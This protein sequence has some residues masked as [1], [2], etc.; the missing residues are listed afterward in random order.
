MSIS[1]EFL[2]ILVCPVDKGEL[3]EL[4]EEHRLQCTECGR[5]YLIRDGLPLL[6]AQEVARTAKKR[7]DQISQPQSGESENE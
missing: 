6:L 1:K 5:E 2:E 4:Q 7:N 3:K